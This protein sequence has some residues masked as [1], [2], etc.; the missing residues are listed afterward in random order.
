MKQKRALAAGVTVLGVAL[1]WAVAANRQ[2]DQTR[3][4]ARQWVGEQWDVA[5][6]C[7]VGTPFGRR[8]AEAEVADR[9]AAMAIDTLVAAELED[10]AP[11]LEDVWPAR[12]APLLNGL[13][14]DPS[15]TGG[16]DVTRLV[17]ELDALSRHALSMH[18]VAG[19]LSRTRAMA[20]PIHAL[21]AAMPPGAEYDLSRFEAPRADPTPIEASLRCR[22]RVTPAPHP[23]APDCPAPPAAAGDDLQLAR[24]PNGLVAVAEGRHT[25]LSLGW[26]R[27]AGGWSAPFPVPRGQLTPTGDAIEACGERWTWSPP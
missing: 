7:I 9:L 14:V 21:D 23:C 3:A 8:D 16:T 6:R 18:D 17:A 12:C 2:D 11:D 25:G 27:R 26:T 13:R 15:V 4:V 24:T 20:R 1:I 10:E 5:R 22:D 19:S